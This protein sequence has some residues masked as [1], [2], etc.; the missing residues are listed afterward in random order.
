M[1]NHP[2]A[3]LQ[4]SE[5]PEEFADILAELR[6][7]SRSRA[8]GYY[9]EVGDRLLR[10]FFGGQATVYLDKDPHKPASFERFLQ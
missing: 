5:P 9:I 10:R 4:R 7:L 2:L 8:L 1:A 3:T 6:Q